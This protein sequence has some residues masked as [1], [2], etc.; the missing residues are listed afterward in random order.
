MDCKNKI[1]IVTGASK[2]LGAALCS[3]LIRHGATVYGLARNTE[4]LSAIKKGLGAAFFPVTLDISNREAVFKWISRTF[5]AK[6]YPDILINNAG[7][8]HFDKID[9]LSLEK[10]HAMI[11][12]NINGLFYITSKIVP[13]MK[14]NPNTCHIINIG[15]ILG[16]TSR[17]EAAAYSLTKYGIQGFSEALFKELRYDKIKVS[18]VN[19]GSIAT[20]FFEESGIEAHHNML[21]PSALAKC[22]LNLIDTDDNFLIDEIT[23]RPLNPRV[24]RNGS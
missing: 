19:P 14:H 6:P 7:A 9:Q 3:E 16:K 2:G 12:T 22:V 15:S 21:R 13:L 10:W 4:K 23:I 11:N 20:D 1:A 24:D 17:A 18:C 5:S 8:G